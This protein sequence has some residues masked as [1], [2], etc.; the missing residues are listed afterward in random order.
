MTTTSFGS[1]MNPKPDKAYFLNP[2][3][4][5]MKMVTISLKWLIVGDSHHL[6]LKCHRQFPR[7]L[8]DIELSPSLE[9]VSDPT[10]NFS[11]KLFWIQAL[12]LWPISN[13]NSPTVFTYINR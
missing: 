10:S 12:S 9:L 1:G 5:P 7:D 8:G 11:L 3:Q 6:K 13:K 4:I 2:A